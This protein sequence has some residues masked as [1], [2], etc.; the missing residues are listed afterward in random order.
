[1]PTTN[2]WWKLPE[3][4]PI[5]RTVLS[6]GPLLCCS[7]V[8]PRSGVCS[9]SPSTACGRA[10]RDRPVA[11][12]E[13][14]TR[15]AGVSCSDAGSVPCQSPKPRAFTALRAQPQRR[16][17]FTANRVKRGSPSL[18]REILGLKR[19]GNVFEPLDRGCPLGRP[20]EAVGCPRCDGV[21]PRRGS[22]L[23][24]ARG[25]PECHTS[26]SALCPVTVLHGG[27]TV[28]V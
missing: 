14:S 23:V 22:R 1:M 10:R 26:R 17:P 13:P 5:P 28:P 19:N 16:L 9:P 7:S 18:S 2:G 21:G 8:L 4:C 20:S 27:S 15:H 6:D 12:S 24:G 11:E 3:Q 25:C